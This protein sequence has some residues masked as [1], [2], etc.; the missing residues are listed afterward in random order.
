MEPE[1]SNVSVDQHGAID[2]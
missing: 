1:A 2:S